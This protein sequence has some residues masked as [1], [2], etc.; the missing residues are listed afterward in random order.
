MEMALF[1]EKNALSQC[2]KLD[3]Q[4]ETNPL[5]FCMIIYSLLPQMEDKNRF[6]QEVCNK[7]LAI[8]DNGICACVCHLCKSNS[9]GFSA[10][11]FVY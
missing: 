1:E 4:R 8:D 6:L 11:L 5:L 3:C 7:S 9:G 2:S 10:D